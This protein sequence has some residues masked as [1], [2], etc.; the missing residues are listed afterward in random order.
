MKT[1]VRKTLEKQMQILSERAAKEDLQGAL[2][3]T[4]QL[5]ELAAIL[6]PEVKE[7][8]AAKANNNFDDVTC[9]NPL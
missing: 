3:I 9:F 1:L 7:K 6:D 2:A 4:P 5:I 8:V